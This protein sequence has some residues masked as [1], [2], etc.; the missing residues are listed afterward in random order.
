M[1]SK[2]V[3]AW[4]F[5]Y[6]CICSSQQLTNQSTSDNTPSVAATD[7]PI[8]FSSPAC[9]EK[10]VK[11][12][13]TV[14]PVERTIAGKTLTIPANFISAGNFG[15]VRKT[16]NEA[17]VAIFMPKFI[18]YSPDNWRNT[19][20]N[21]DY[22]WAAIKSASDRSYIDIVDEAI[23]SSIS[24]NAP[25]SQ[26]LGFDA[27]LYDFRKNSTEES[28]PTYIAKNASAGDP[29]FVLCRQPKGGEG[30]CELSLIDTESNLFVRARFAVKHAP[31][32][33]EIEN[34]LRKLISNWI[35]R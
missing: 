10:R 8:Q 24:G 14:T 12:N 4:I 1:N 29:A 28:I 17:T 33:L 19:Y 34:G 3:L 26:A 35:T 27:Y 7:C 9:E 15:P 31:Q 21:S 5:F 22:I 20:A 16:G 6:S 13:F 30:R 11:K 2:F 25:V 18:G 23:K 32:W